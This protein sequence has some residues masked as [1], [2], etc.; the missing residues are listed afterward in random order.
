M[1]DRIEVIEEQSTVVVDEHKTL[2]VIEETGVEVVTV[3]TQGPDGI[4]GPPGTPLVTSVAGKQGAVT[5]VPGDVGLEFVNNTSD[6][7]KPV[8]ALSLIHI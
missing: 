5:L 6:A 3:G 8:S 7:A 4:P 2:A 1:A